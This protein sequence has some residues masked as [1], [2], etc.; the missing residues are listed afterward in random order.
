MSSIHLLIITFFIS[1][2]GLAIQNQGLRGFH[3]STCSLSNSGPCVV[4][5]SRQAYDIV[6]L[7]V[8][9]NLRKPTVKIYAD[10]SQKTPKAIYTGS[11]GTLNLEDLELVLHKDI[12]SRNQLLVEMKTGEAINL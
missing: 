4:I 7:G 12:H 2:S 3:F 8:A 1:S 5:D 6:A 10:R 11:S 9:Y